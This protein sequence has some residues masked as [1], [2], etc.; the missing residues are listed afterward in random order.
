MSVNAGADGGMISGENGLVAGLGLIVNLLNEIGPQTSKT[1]WSAFL[2]RQLSGRSPWI[3]GLFHGFR[4]GTKRNTSSIVPVVSLD[5]AQRVRQLITSDLRYLHFDREGITTTEAPLGPL[6]IRLNEQFQRATWRAQ[7]LGTKKASPGQAILTL[8]R[9]A[10]RKERWVVQCTP[11]PDTKGLAESLY[12]I[13][14]K[15]LLSGTLSRLRMCRHCGRYLVVKSAKQEVCK[16]CKPAYQNKRRAD[17]GYFRQA[18]KER[19]ESRKR[20]ARRLL[21]EKADQGTI[22]LVTKLSPRTIERLAEEV[23]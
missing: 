21:R 6:L 15:A 8:R 16:E 7:L 10:N 14:G 23:K 3:S 13:L 4:T 22:Q 2:K 19:T 20:K 9:R 11:F 5:E 17:Q 1:K 12:A 18:Y